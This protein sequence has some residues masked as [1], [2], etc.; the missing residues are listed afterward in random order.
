M[1][2]ALIGLLGVLVGSWLSE[3]FR[4]QNRIELYSS[5]VFEHRLEAYE[6]LFSRL[7]DVE[8][9]LFKIIEDETGTPDER[10]NK[11][12]VEGFKVIT[13]TDEKAFYLN[14]EV[15]VHCCG[16]IVGSADVIAEP[17]GK[18]RDKMISHLRSEFRRAMELIRA[19]SGI[20]EINKYWQAVSKAELSSPIIE[21]YRKVKADWE[22]K[23]K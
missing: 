11:G 1:T 4:R 21:Y 23:Q 9:A 12:V 15:T 19:E 10:H 8:T 18:K 7:R 6:G 14:E 17:P 2:A 20:T 13:Y 5:K 3:L 22:A 16:T